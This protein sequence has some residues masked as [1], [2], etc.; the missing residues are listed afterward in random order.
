MFLRSSDKNY[1]SRAGSALLTKLV[2]KRRNRWSEA[3][4]SIDFL[5]FSRKARSILNNLTGRSRHS[6][7]HC[8]VS[9]DAIASQLVRNG[10]YEDVNCESSRLISQEISDLWG[11]TTT[12]PVNI[13]GNFSSRAFSVALQRLQPGKASGPNSIFPGLTFLFGVYWIRL[14]D[15]GE[16]DAPFSGRIKANSAA[17]ELN[18]SNIK[19]KGG[20]PNC[21]VG[22]PSNNS[23][24]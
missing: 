11:A 7:R 12:N 18:I 19:T 16:R 10:K 4:Q 6:S 8:F 22:L 3:V 2:R 17:K 20:P 13:S 24:L 21:E 14:Y 5:N 1:S 9:A 23:F 15:L